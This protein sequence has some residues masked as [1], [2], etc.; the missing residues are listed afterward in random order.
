MLELDLEL[1]LQLELARELQSGLALVPELVGAP[2][3]E[4]EEELVLQLEV[5]PEPRSDLAREDW[6]DPHC[7]HR[8]RE[9]RMGIGFHFLPNS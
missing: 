6:R 4:L 7:S 8:I 3:P 1:A 9:R 5:V 2:E